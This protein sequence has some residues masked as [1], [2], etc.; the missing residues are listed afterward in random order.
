MRTHPDYPDV[1]E[2]SLGAAR[3]L[4][5][6]KDAVCAGC[7]H[8]KQMSSEEAPTCGVDMEDNTRDCT[9]ETVWYA[10]HIYLAN[11]LEQRTGDQR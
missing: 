1:V 9:P 11:K 6:P 3:K 2:L 5:A 8:H 4:I 7:P 10:Q